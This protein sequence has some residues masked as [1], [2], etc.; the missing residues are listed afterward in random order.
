MV[1]IAGRNRPRVIADVTI[2]GLRNEEFIVIPP[3]SGWTSAQSPW[4][5]WVVSRRVV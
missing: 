4:G 5:P 1:L 2:E 3:P